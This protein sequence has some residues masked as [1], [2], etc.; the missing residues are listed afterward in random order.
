MG[1][2]AYPSQAPVLGPPC[3]LSRRNALLIII[4]AMTSG[5]YFWPV[6]PMLGWGIGVAAHAASVYLGPTEISE[7]KID[8]ELHGRLGS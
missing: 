8:R 6:W 1:Y 7:A 5:E 3:C 4:W 2:P